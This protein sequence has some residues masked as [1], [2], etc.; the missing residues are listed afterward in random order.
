MQ[1]AKLVDARGAICCRHTSGLPDSHARTRP[2]SA[3]PRRFAA[4]R[5]LPRILAGD[6]ERL[7]GVI[8]EDV[9]N[10]TLSAKR[11]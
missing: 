9:Q 2:E 8:A 10:P 4:K 1:P 5:T 6:V 11:P 3:R 7:D